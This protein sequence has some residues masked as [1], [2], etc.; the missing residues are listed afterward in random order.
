VASVNAMAAL[1]ASRPFVVRA[2]PSL[3]VLGLLGSTSPAP[4]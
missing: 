1:V 3:L 2:D 4:L